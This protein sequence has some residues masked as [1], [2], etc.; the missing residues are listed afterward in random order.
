MPEV[1]E[2]LVAVVV[3]ESSVVAMVR[4]QAEVVGWPYLDG[5]LDLFEFH[6]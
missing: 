3:E 1:L 6:K 4:G 2:G 5:L